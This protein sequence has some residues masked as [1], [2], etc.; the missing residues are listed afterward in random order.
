MV[1]NLSHLPEELMKILFN[2]LPIRDIVNLRISNLYIYNLGQDKCLWE[3]IARRDYHH[4]F[5][6]FINYTDQNRWEELVKYLT[7]RKIIPVYNN[8]TLQTIIGYTIIAPNNT[9]EDLH[10][11]LY[12]IKI[13]LSKSTDH[14]PILKL[15]KCSFENI[16]PGHVTGFGLLLTN[17]HY[18]W[19]HASDS[20]A[21]STIYQFSKFPQIQF[22]GI[23]FLL[24][25]P[26]DKNKLANVTINELFISIKLNP[27]SIYKI[28]PQ[29]PYIQNKYNLFNSLQCIYT[30]F[31]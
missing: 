18:T 2:K 31:W 24:N 22:P 4:V 25:L 8:V 21:L 7:W 5:S 28:L 10:T 29:V 13:F 27:F 20:G 16:R 11:L 30:Y 6:A 1:D 23:D 9:M 14:L 15:E 3:M 19:I 17:S 26:A 12:Y